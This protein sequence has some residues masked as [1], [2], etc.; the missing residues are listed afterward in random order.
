MINNQCPIQFMT[1]TDFT[2]IVADMYTIFQLLTIW[3][4]ITFLNKLSLFIK[5]KLKDVKKIWFH[6]STQILMAKD[7]SSSWTVKWLSM[8]KFSI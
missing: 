2:L 3:Q 5:L 8:S 7:L 4:D 1:G 6:A